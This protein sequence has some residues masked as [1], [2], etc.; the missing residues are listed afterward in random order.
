[1]ICSQRDQ[2]QRPSGDSRGRSQRELAPRL[3]SRAVCGSSVSIRPTF[4]L[5]TSCSEGFNIAPSL[6]SVRRE[7][8]RHLTVLPGGGSLARARFDDRAW[9]PDRLCRV[10]PAARPA[11]LGRPSAPW[12]AQCWPCRRRADAATRPVMRSGGVRAERDSVCP[13]FSNATPPTVRLR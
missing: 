3:W 2:S 6:T 10:L 9:R 7:S 1:L 4:Q 13:A 5:P 8:P 11:A 12:R